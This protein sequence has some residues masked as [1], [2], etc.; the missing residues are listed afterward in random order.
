MAALLGLTAL[1]A[2]VGGLS[3]FLTLRMTSTFRE[4]SEEYRPFL[5]DMNDLGVYMDRAI[6]LAHETE[7]RSGRESIPELRQRLDR[8]TESF[9]AIHRHLV[10]TNPDHEEILRVAE[11]L[12]EDH[13]QFMQDVARLL[14][15][16]SREIALLEQTQKARRAAGERL[17]ELQ[18]R[19]AAAAGIADVQNSDPTSGSAL[20]RAGAARGLMLLFELHALLGELAVEPSRTE[21]TD[22]SSSAETLL[23]RLAG[24]L[25]ADGAASAPASSAANGSAAPGT[26]TAVSALKAALLEDEGYLP[27]YAAYLDAKQRAAATEQVLT[28]DIM[29]T[30]RS[31]N[32]VVGM[33]DIFRSESSSFGLLVATPPIM[34]SAVLVAVALSLILGFLL[35][36]S[37]TAPVARL[38]TAMQALARGDY[39]HRVAI[40]T[41]DELEQ[42]GR[43]F[44]EMA[45]RL[46][47]LNHYLEHQVAAR[48]EKLRQEVKT[49]RQAEESLRESEERYRT[50][51]ESF[52]RGAIALVDQE[53]TIRVAGG[54]GT[55]WLP[56]RSGEALDRISGFETVE[57]EPLVLAEALEPTF[58]GSHVDFECRASER[59]WACH[60]V[61]NYPTAEGAEEEIHSITILFLDI[62]ELRSAERRVRETQRQ[63]LQAD[64]MAALGMLVAGVA[65]EI[66]NP[67]QSIGMA[68]TVLGHYVDELAPELERLAA[69]EPGDT[70]A[71]QPLSE[72]PSA[73]R[74]HIRSIAGG[75][76]RI[77]RIAQGLRAFASNGGSHERSAVDVNL[78]VKSALFLLDSMVR[79]ATDR[80]ELS[81]AAE[82]PPISA[83]AQRVEQVVVNLV[84]NACQALT[85]PH[86]AVRVS[87]AHEPEE[88][89][90]SLV[91]S[92]QGVGIAPDALSKVRDP[93]YTTKRDAG[94]T[95]LGLSVVAGILEDHG[96]SLSIESREWEGTTVTCR[97]PIAESPGERKGSA[98]G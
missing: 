42:L 81:L 82:L 65:H 12:Q 54:S 64:K 70:I 84:Q 13:D 43:G 27:S 52:P 29:D 77:H 72:V 68:A 66:G 22:I 57:G 21:L 31:L 6:R 4:L 97:F 7:L 55:G 79:K 9:D 49:R 38:Q 60:A 46:E 80:F 50:L 61:A 83:D 91:V 89:A 85:D 78:V 26:G 41:G 73:L 94:G 14:Q 5:R 17:T 23:E 67:N 37:V 53:R 28:T 20:S 45:Q 24:A 95:G 34:V 51:V 1:T 30:V 90:V 47:Q 69:A 25:G 36:R 15:D 93:F 76:E 10:E 11:R 48:T 87:T 98:D 88:R 96:G 71:G 74:A 86:Q 75:S 56:L 35:T 3:M 44:N 2:L 40:S 16:Y 19:L 33:A 18:G 39:A 63:L 92:D 62:T 32:S 58:S 59:Q 8:A